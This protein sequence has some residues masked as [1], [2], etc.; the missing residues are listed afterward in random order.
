MTI[1]DFTAQMV[2]FGLGLIG[3]LAVVVAALLACVDDRERRA[4]R[5]WGA[6]VRSALMG[7]VH[8][9]RRQ[10]ALRNG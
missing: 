6:N 1:I 2:P 5:L 4:L 9:S 8:A 10:M 3:V 7:S